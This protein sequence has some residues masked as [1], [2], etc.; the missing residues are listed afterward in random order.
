MRFGQRI[1]DAE[2]DAKLKDLRQDPREEFQSFQRQFDAS[3]RQLEEVTA[4]QHG[5][6]FKLKSFLA[7]LHP[8]V[9]EKVDLEGPNTFEEAL[10]LACQ[11]SKKIKRKWEQGSMDLGGGLVMPHHQEAGDE[12]NAK[13]PTNTHDAD[14]VRSLQD[15]SQQMNELCLNLFD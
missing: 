10:N 1:S 2:A 4:V 6:Y 8:K 15:I 7:C 12:G 11:K 14:L 3:W 9:R 5:D 13:A